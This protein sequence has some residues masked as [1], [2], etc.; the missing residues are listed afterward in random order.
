MLYIETDD[1]VYQLF[2]GDT[3]DIPVNK[4]V[5]VRACTEELKHILR[6]CALIPHCGDKKS[7]AWFGD[8]AKFIAYN[9][10]YV[11]YWTKQQWQG[12]LDQVP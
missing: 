3:I 8:H 4:V 12:L 7:Q 9:C 5:S 1:K 2:V 11:H 6:T 10:G